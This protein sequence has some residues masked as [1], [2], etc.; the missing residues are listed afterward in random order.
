[1]DFAEYVSDGNATCTSDGTKTAKCTRCEATDTV[2]DEGSMLDHTLGDWLSDADA[3]WRH[4]SE[5]DGNF[6]RGA[7]ELI[8][9]VTKKA[10]AEENGLK[11]EICSICGYKTGNSETVEYGGHEPGDINNDGKVNNKDLTRLFQY[12]SDWDVEVNEDA[13]DV[14][15]DGKINNKDLTRL[16][17][18]L[19]DW[20]VEIF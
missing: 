7:H 14:N 17:Q 16:F 20:D 1:H 9:K 18:Y 2:T 11:E 4:C 3:H 6:D 15:G 12:L 10:T 5:C 19:S 13:L 8:W